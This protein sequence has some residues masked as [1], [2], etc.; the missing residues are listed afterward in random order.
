MASIHKSKTSGVY[1]VSFRWAG[2]QFLKSTKT[3][4]LREARAIQTRV[5]DTIKGLRTGRI[6]NPEPPAGVDI[7]DYILSGCSLQ[8][9]R[10]RI[11]LK[12]AIEQ[13]KDESLDKSPNTHATEAK[14]LRHVER[15]LRGTTRLDTI[16]LKQIKRYAKTRHGEGVQGGTIRQEFVT[17]NQLW[18]WARKE[19]FV[20]GTT[21]TKEATNPKKWA[22]A[23]EKQKQTKQ[24]ATWTEIEKRIAQEKTPADEQGGVWSGLYLDDV[25]IAELLDCVQQNE[26]YGFLVPAFYLAALAGLRRSEILR[27]LVSDI[28]FADNYLTVHE[29]KRV[30]S[31]QTST[32]TVP[33][34]KRLKTYLE[35]FLASRKASDPHILLDRQGQPL[36]A[37][38]IRKYFRYALK[39]SKFKVLPGWHC[40]RH[41]FA[42][43]C[44]RKNIPMKVTA[45]W[46][47]HTTSEM[48]EL[49][50]KTFPQDEQNYISRL[51]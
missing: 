50:Q 43:I 35:S 5:D 24:F 51:D 38:S 37:D 26:R 33:L 9:V 17:F 44:L 6:P 21:P 3:T 18:H 20:D 16:D 32:R 46:M 30:K 25:Q 2:R 27:V 19:H 49:Y 14:H 45:N 40:L 29:K 12:D 41:S 10:Q 23:L 13:Y 31:R 42:S 8:A 22:V 1:N 34:S 15:I 36:N 11:S 28:Q 7:G 39:D 4:S 48:I 47:G